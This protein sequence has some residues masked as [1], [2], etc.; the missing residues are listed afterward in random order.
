MQDNTD[1]QGSRYSILPHQ[2][3]LLKHTQLQLRNT[4]FQLNTMT[5]F[6]AHF[7]RSKITLSIGLAILVSVSNITE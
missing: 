3:H 7:K 4:L 6:I 2:K 1:L 5:T